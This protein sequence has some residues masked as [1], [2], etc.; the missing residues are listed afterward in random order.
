[1]YGIFEQAYK[2]A[3]HTRFRDHAA[4][5]MPRYEFD[6]VAM[7]EAKKA[8]QTEFVY[9]LRWPDE[10]TKIDAWTAFMADREWNEIKKASRDPGSLVGRIE[11]RHLRPRR[12]SEG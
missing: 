1:M 11:D 6:I 4:R 2:D 9:L 7:W 8:E 5:I 3:F 12:C 10:R